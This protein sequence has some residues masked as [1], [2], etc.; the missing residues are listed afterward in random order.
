[1]R[2]RSF[3]G[4]R[5][6]LRHY[7]EETALQNLIVQMERRD[8]TAARRTAIELLKKG[9][10]E[11]ETFHAV[12]AAFIDGGDAADAVRALKKYRQKFSPDGK[13]NFYAGRVAYL[14]GEWSRAEQYFLAACQDDGLSAWYKGAAYSILGTLY[15]DE[16]RTVEAANCYKQAAALKTIDTGKAAEYANY[17]FNLHYT[18]KALDLSFMLAAAKG[19]GE[20]FSGVPRFSHA[21]R[22]RNKIRVGYISPDLRFHVVYFFSDAMFRHYNRARFE[23]YCYT[24]CQEDKTSGEIRRLTDGWRNVRGLSYAQI[25]QVIYDDGIDILVDLAGHTAWSLLPVLAYKPAPVQISG[26]G[27]FDTTGLDTVDYFLADNYT[28][29]PENDACF[30]EKLLRLTGSHFC[31][32]WHDRDVPLN[33]APCLTNNY[34]TFGSFN[35]FAK[36]TDGQLSLWSEILRSVPNSRLMLKAGIFNTIAGRKVAEKKLV[37]AGLPPERLIVSPHEFNYLSAYNRVDIGLDTFPYP[38]GGTTCDALYMGVPVITRVGQSHN[39]RFGYSLLM[40]VN[41]PE[42]CAFSAADYVQKAVA[43]AA[44]YGHINELRLSLRSRLQNSPVMRPVDY[45]A[46]LEIIY[47]GIWGKYLANGKLSAAEL[48]ADLTKATQAE[49]WSRT[50]SLAAQIIWLKRNS[51]T[52]WLWGAIACEHLNNPALTVWWADK[53]IEYNENIV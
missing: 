31:F 40:N 2:R 11:R 51:P 35:N 39:S 41:L 47:E 5:K 43:L 19:Y 10:T 42:C 6:K 53:G 49:D 17:L 44:D 28:D 7:S 34:V 1:M 21:R 24:N 4:W 50:L 18:D 15:R 8:W 9:I 3:A 32:K 26:I 52:A 48:T 30:T 23:V 22:Q 45:M 14:Q 37:A 46:E 33:A 12:L 29:P 25:A 36:L 38:G 16:G 27:Y 13:G 20:L